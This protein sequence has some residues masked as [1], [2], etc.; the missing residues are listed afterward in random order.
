MTTCIAQECAPTTTSLSRKNSTRTRV[1]IIPP[2]IPPA[3]ENTAC[4]S[5]MMHVSYHEHCSMTSPV[6]VL[7]VRRSTGL[8]TASP[9][10][11]LTPCMK[12]WGA[13]T[14]VCFIG[15]TGHQCVLNNGRFLAG[16]KLPAGYSL[17]C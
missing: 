12:V 10:I 3:K 2:E 16:L 4:V 14:Q 5:R 8:C 13:K 17:P 9:K 7:Y 11:L 15:P 1:V 6:A